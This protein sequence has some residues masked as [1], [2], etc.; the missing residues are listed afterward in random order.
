ICERYI[1]T[2]DGK[3]LKDYKIH[4]FHGEPKLIQVDYERF[5][6]HTRNFY[7]LEWNLVELRWGTPLQNTDIRDSPPDNLSAMLSIARA[8]SDD[9]GY[10]RVDLYDVEGRI[11]FGELTLTPLSGLVK[12]KPEAMNAIMG[13]WWT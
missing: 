6:E 4:C 11:I 9:F 7:D 3:D 10:V 1:E 12:P 13:S 2:T 8:L 5:T